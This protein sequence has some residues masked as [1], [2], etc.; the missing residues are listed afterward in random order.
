MGNGKKHKHKH[1]DD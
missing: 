1:H